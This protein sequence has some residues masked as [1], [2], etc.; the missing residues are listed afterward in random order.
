MPYH[1]AMVALLRPP[2]QVGRLTARAM[3]DEQRGR[4]SVLAAD[5]ERDVHRTI[6]VAS[7]Q[8]EL[9]PEQHVQHPPICITHVARA[10]EQTMP[11]VHSSAASAKTRH[12]ADA[13]MDD[14]IWVARRRLWSLNCVEARDYSRY[15]IACSPAGLQL[16][17]PRRNP[18]ARYPLSRMERGA[19][20]ALLALFVFLLFTLL[21]TPG[22][23]AETRTI[24][25]TNGD[26]VTGAKPTYH[27]SWGFHG[28]C[29]FCSDAPSNV[30][31]S[32]DL[33]L[34]HDG[35]FHASHTAN[36]RVTFTF[37][38]EQQA[39]PGKFARLIAP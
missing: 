28:H 30:R 27:G 10:G 35:T 39:R 17:P 26:S 14:G 18:H 24:D 13:G 11:S 29:D 1:M 23:T 4:I 32:F 2:V 21:A 22:V 7:E 31:Q 20:R 6:L 25:D 38:G 36:D 12:L 16:A 33:S 19:R 15:G 5:G 34:V 9:R 3:S 8:S 37:T